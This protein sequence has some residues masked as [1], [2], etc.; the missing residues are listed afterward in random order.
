MFEDPIKLSD[1]N[2]VLESHRSYREFISDEQ[3]Q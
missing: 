2:Q 1:Q 3:L